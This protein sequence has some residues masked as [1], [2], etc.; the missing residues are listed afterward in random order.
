MK[1]TITFKWTGTSGAMQLLWEHIAYI[2][3]LSG[4]AENWE[5]K[6]EHVKW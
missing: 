1:V 2:L 6:E 3:S 5:M 4:Q